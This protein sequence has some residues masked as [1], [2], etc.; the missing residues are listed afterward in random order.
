MEI[1]NNLRVLLAKNDMSQKEFAERNGIV[2]KTV[3]LT[4]NQKLI[5]YPLPLIHAIAREFNITDM[6]E[7]FT[8][9]TE[10]KKN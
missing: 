9:V 2:E 7:I 5:R 3:S 6:N 10:D 4:V 1:K 8:I